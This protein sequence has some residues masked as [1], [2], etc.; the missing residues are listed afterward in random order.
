MTKAAW[1]LMGT[2]PSGKWRW[3]VGLH[4]IPAQKQL[5]LHVVDKKTDRCIYI[6]ICIYIYMGP[7]PFSLVG[8]GD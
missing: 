1:V 7:H 3:P 2:I 4:R 8:G 5:G 6:Y